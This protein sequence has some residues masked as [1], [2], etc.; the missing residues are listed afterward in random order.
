MFVVLGATGNTG[1]VVAETLLGKKQSVRVVVRSQEKGVAWKSKGAEVAVA[2]LDDVPALTKAFEG[3]NG[4]YVLVPPNYGAEAWLADQRTRMDRAAEAVNKS[5][6]SHV[7]FLSSIGGQLS[8]GTG[9]IRAL[10]YGEG[11]LAGAVKHVTI[12]RPPSFMENWAPV[13][14]TAKSQEVLPTFVAPQV[15]IPTIST[16]DI[17]RIGAEQLLSGGQG[18]KVVELA[19]PEEYSADQAAEALST[20]LGKKVI[21]QHAPLSVVVPTYKTFGFS[22]EVAHL[23]EEMYT[24]FSRNAIGYE[25]PSSL[26]RGHVTLTDALRAMV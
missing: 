15:K 16:R 11:K 24:G 20:I 8:G 13:I 18:R 26:V 23:F 19:G 1:A 17:G 4:V 3:A 14:G 25:H 21:A 22:D 2:S 5:G 9:P 10:H 6:V 12:L 7:V